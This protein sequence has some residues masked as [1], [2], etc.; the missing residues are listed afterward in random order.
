MTLGHPL[1]AAFAAA[2]ALLAAVVPAAS[3]GS[4]VR[5]VREGER[6]RLTFNG[7]PFFLCGVG[8]DGSRALLSS[9]G[10]NTFR[11]WGADRAR[12]DLDEAAA[13]KL[14]VML[15]FWLGHAEHGFDYTNAD[16]LRGTRESVLRTVRECK[17][18]PAL[19]CW[20]LGNEME[21][22]NPHP[23]EMWRFID[24][25]AAEIKAV[26]PDHPV[27]TVVAEIWPEK[28][29]QMERLCPHLDFV[30]INSY[31]GCGSVG[32]RWREY[33]GT[34]PYVVTEFG[35]WSAE[36]GGRS[37][38]GCPLEPTSTEKA[39]W[40]AKVYD[41]GIGG[42]AGRGCL[43]SYAFVW[44]TKIEGTPTWFGLLTPD[45][46]VLGA[47]QALQEKWGR[48]P[49]RNHVPAI[50]PL[51]L[52]TDQPAPGALVEAEASAT[53]PDGD[54]LTWRW[55]LVEENGHYGATELGGV[56]PKRFEE[57]IVEGQG[58]PRA[59]VRLPGAG[60]FRLYAYCFDGK[61]HA[62]YANAPLQGQ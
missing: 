17:D 46:S 48:V 38:F 26:D 41:E 15:G 3:G 57:A 51:R 1:L 29:A 7:R 58:T 8:G 56:E 55:V 25:L 35:P 12:H 59:K 20:A 49:V 54:P 13:N 39:E 19:L 32:R 22:G 21:L 27:C 34:K 37:S 18:H 9:M 4:V 2:S 42:E 28:V 61:T 33:G 62:A 24:E 23:E 36:E 11:T 16:A 10:G 52:S 47:A 6:A 5:L 53:D 44:G 45:G 31:G 14:A 50:K 43:G 60:K 30:G 40:Y